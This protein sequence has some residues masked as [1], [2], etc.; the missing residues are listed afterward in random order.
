[1]SVAASVV[2]R[3]RPG[4]AF[5]VSQDRVALLDLD[6]PDA[7]ASVL[8]GTAALIWLAIDGVRTTEGI[9]EHV[10]AAHRAPPSVVGPDVAAFV[11]ELVARG[12]VAP[13]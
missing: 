2:P 12:L 11:A 13:A 10:A 3:H 8:E 5:V 6:Q 4:V 9:A 1:V 7:P